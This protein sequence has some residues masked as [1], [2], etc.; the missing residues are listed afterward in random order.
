MPNSESAYGLY[1]KT[2]CQW[3]AKS[4][5]IDIPRK[6]HCEDGVGPPEP[7]Q[8]IVGMTDYSTFNVPCKWGPCTALSLEEWGELQAAENA[9]LRAAVGKFLLPPKTRN[10]EALKS[11]T[12]YCHFHPEQRFWQ[13]LRNWSK[14]QFI[15][16]AEVRG[17]ATLNT[18]NIEGLDGTRPADHDAATGTADDAPKCK[19][20]PHPKHDSRC[21]ED[22]PNAQ[23]RCG[24][25]G[26]C[27]HGKD[28]A[29][30]TQCNVPQGANTRPRSVVEPPTK[31][32]LWLKINHVRGLLIDAHITGTLDRSWEFLLGALQMNADEHLQAGGTA[33]AAGESIEPEGVELSGNPGE[34]EPPKCARCNGMRI[35]PSEPR[36]IAVDC[37]D[38]KGTGKAT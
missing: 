20:C 22:A 31:I 14:W 12:R 29:Y 38:C 34:P 18:F 25:A 10:S 19:L 6:R 33:R 26:P 11:F 9:E 32:D 30:C 36:K 13:A 37:P 21:E 23:F 27:P 28:G 17:G 35:V 7:D 8:H 3:C 5:P 4:I 1:R 24:C 15:L 2:V 16:G